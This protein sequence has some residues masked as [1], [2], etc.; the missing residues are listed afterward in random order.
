MGAVHVMGTSCGCLI[1]V[2]ERESA[3]SAPELEPDSVLIPSWYL[4]RE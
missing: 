2:V 1:V 4:K 3:R